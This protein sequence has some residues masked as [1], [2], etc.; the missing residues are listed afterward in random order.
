MRR[1]VLI[2]AAVMTGVCVS[3]AVV[4]ATLQ[5]V[6]WLHTGEQAACANVWLYT[7]SDCT[8]LYGYTA[9]DSCGFYQFTGLSQG[10]T[11]YIHIEFPIMNCAHGSYSG[12]CDYTEIDCESVTMSQIRLIT[13]KD[14]Y[15]NLPDC[16]NVGCP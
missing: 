15:L 4:A 1:L 11:Y 8:S 2:V 12:D 5:G 13:V 7:N 16:Y 9:T 6:V 10:V 14:W 3:G